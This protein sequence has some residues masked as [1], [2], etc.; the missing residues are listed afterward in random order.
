MSSLAVYTRLHVGELTGVLTLCERRAARVRGAGRRRCRSHRRTCGA[1]SATRRS[2]STVST[3]AMVVTAPTLSFVT[4]TWRR[5]HRRDLGEMRDDQHVIVLGQV[6]E[7]TADGRRRPAADPGVDL[8]EHQGAGR[9]VLATGQDEPEG[10]HRPRQLAA[11]GHLGEGEQRR[12][13]L[14]DEQELDPVALDRSSSS[15]TS[16]RELGVG[17]GKADAS[18]ATA[19]SLSPGAAVRRARRTASA[20]RSLGF[21]AAAAAAE[22]GSPLLEPLELGRTWTR[23][24]SRRAITGVEPVAVLAR[25]PR[26]V[27]RRA[28]TSPSCRDRLDRLDD[29]RIRRRRRRSRR[30][31]IAGVRRIV[32]RAR[33]RRASRPPTPVHHVAARR[34]GAD[35]GR[36]PC[37]PRGAL[38]HRPAHPPAAC[39]LGILVDVVEAGAV[40]LVSW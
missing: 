16:M 31:A 28:R 25:Q 30:T 34:L 40:E 38:R 1:T 19:R 10:E 33:G 13:G 12:P 9:V 23:L 6:S 20:A 7:R 21:R 26:G 5:R 11:R 35:R 29:A 32:V 15:P 3:R 24:S 22:L 8:V 2:P 27:G 17:K 37:R 4:A 14:A 18:C 36:R 39:Q